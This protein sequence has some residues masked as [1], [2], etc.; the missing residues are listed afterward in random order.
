MRVGIIVYSHT[1]NT[2]SVAQKLQ[3]A[4]TAAGHDAKI[5]RVEPV[6]DDLGKSG[7]AEL[8]SNPDV[9]IYDAVIFASPVQAFSLA[10]VMRLYLSQVSGLNGKKVYCFVT[11]GLKMKWLGG[12][13]SVRQIKSACRTRGED[14]IASDIVNWSSDKREKQIE[15]IVNRFV[16]DLN[17]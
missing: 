15:D 8:K 11:Q 6:N 2:L 12:N 1:G 16:N 14:V 4:L 10:R 7:P 17:I 13:H 9:S 3:E 5:E